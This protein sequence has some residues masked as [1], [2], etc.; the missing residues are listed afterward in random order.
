MKIG[1]N[2]Q[3]LSRSANYRSAGVSGYS[4]ALLRELGAL[5]AAGATGHSFDAFVN[6]PTLALPGVE[7]VVS[8]LPLQRPLLRIVWEQTWLPAFLAQGGYDLVHGLVN[9]LPLATTARDSGLVH[10]PGVVTVHDLSFVRL[11]EVLPP[12]KRAYLT[13]LC[14]RST[15]QA[16]RVIAV[17][18]QTADDLITSF[19]LPAAKIEVIP[20]GVGGE[21]TPASA[22]SAAQFRARKGLPERFLLYVG[23]L[24]PRKNLELLV[25]A[26]A[27]FRAASPADA[28]VQLVI[29]GG[30]GWYYE[31]VFGAVRALGLE[32]RVRFAGFV[33]G[34]ELPDWYRAA[35]AFVYPSRFEGFGLPLLEAMAS[36]TPVITSTAPSLLEV[37]GD[38]AIAVSPHDEQALADAMALLVGQ[39]AVRAEL[40]RLGPAR[41]AGYSWEQT[42]F[43]TVQVY[44]D[45][46]K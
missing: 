36:G 11:P 13:A 12:A 5:R 46:V 2:A 10:L 30:K 25:R 43:A 21:F 38:A 4:L 23:T 44:E 9:V 7:M 33:P 27:R 37:A 15:L 18:R 26:F 41:A 1:L 14:L 34:E 31:T 28:D 24:E 39:Q 6:H 42:A 22:D 40:R 19:G 32:R 35:L 45:A 3:L 29:A 8:H 20:N 16:K 17:S